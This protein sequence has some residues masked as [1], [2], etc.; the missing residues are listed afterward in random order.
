MFSWSC[1][2]CSAT[3]RNRKVK[4]CNRLKHLHVTYSVTKNGI[5]KVSSGKAIQNNVVLRIGQS[6]SPYVQISEHPFA[7]V[8]SDSA[9]RRTTPF[10]A[11]A[12]LCTEVCTTWAGMQ[13]STAVLQQK[14]ISH[15]CY[16]SNSVLKTSQL[17]FTTVKSEAFALMPPTRRYTP[18]AADTDFWFTTLLT[19][20]K[21]NI[22]RY[23]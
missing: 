17:I 8:T 7:Y 12:G 9:G 3:T 13:V 10:C 18:M 21:F 4:Y 11:G 16:A 6:L 2:T 22:K 23:Q 15:C 5:A 1:N 14:G 20:E 19:E